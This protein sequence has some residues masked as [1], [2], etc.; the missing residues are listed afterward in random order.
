MEKNLKKQFIY[1]L[2][3][4][5]SMEIKYV[6]K[7]NNPERR[8]KSHMSE[9]SLI[10]N[11]TSKNKWLKHLKNNNL[12]PEMEIIDNGPDQNI[13]QLEKKWIIYYKS[14]GIKLTNETEG[15]DGFDWT[16]RK[17]NEEN[18]MKMKMNHPFRKTIIQFDLENNIINKYDSSHDAGIKTGFSR[19]QI[20]N[21]CKGKKFYNTVGKNYYFRFIDN[22]FTC[23]K[24]KSEPNIQIIN[25]LL[26]D[27]KS[28]EKKYL[29]KKE[30]LKIKQKEGAKSRRKIIIQYDLKGNIINKFKS[31]TEASNK[32]R[33][34]IYLISNCCKKKGSYTVG[35][36][37]FWRNGNNNNKIPSTFRYESDLFDYMPYNK[38]IQKNSRKVCKYDLNGNLVEI[39]DS[40]KMASKSINCVAQNI[41]SCCKRK[42]NKKNGNFII[43]KGFTWRYYDETNGNKIYTL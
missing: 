32:T 16:G 10:E 8:L 21:C 43:V 6:G 19:S 12:Y 15:G 28:K 13:N 37:H 27:L 3:D 31:I 22:F 18:I 30:K 5:I 35:G 39:Y 24:S 11:W 42:L 20:V 9:Y 40:I 4:P 17:H 33:I 23:K 41:F 29:N 1:I 2:K 26:D 38:S 34:H 36:G 25:T 14:I 7:S